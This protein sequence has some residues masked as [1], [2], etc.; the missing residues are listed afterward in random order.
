MCWRKLDREVVCVVFYFIG[1]IEVNGVGFK[2]VIFVLVVWF[3]DVGDGWDV[4]GFKLGI[5]RLRFEYFLFI[6]FVVLLILF[7]K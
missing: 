4:G 2:I 5:V 6:L 3:V 1:K 7:Y